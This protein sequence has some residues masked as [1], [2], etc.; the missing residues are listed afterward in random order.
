MAGGGVSNFNCEFWDPSSEWLEEPSP[1]VRQNSQ[2]SPKNMPAWC[3]FSQSL[4]CLCEN[5]RV[6]EGKMVGR[7]I[8]VR[9][10]SL[11][12]KILAYFF[13]VRAW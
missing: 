3:N 12:S 9:Q 1:F 2:K 13:K 6:K 8:K 11:E 4:P 10:K 7:Q 5:H